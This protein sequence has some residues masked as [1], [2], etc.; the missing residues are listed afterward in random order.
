MTA[1]KWNSVRRTLEAA[2]MR[3]KQNGDVD[4]VALFDPANKA[5]ARLGLKVARVKAK[6]VPS[7]AQ[8]AAIAKATAS[9]LSNA[10]QAA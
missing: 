5:Q 1:R 8:L 2:G 3:I 9:R 6:R 4:G 7:S 10:L